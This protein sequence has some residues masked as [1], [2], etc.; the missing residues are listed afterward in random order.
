[1]DLKFI[2]WFLRFKIY[3]KKEEETIEEEKKENLEI[4]TEK[5][6]EKIRNKKNT[7]TLIYI[8]VGIAIIAIIAMLLFQFF[9]SR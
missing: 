6:E 3:R 2:T 4:K 5:E 9:I 8:L 7:F 1:M